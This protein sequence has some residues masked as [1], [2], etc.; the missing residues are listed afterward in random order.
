VATS[1]KKSRKLEM[2]PQRERWHRAAAAVIAATRQDRD[3]T[4]ADFAAQTRWSHDA[5]ANI[6]SGRRKI[7]FG[8]VVMAAIAIEEKPEILYNVPCGGTPQQIEPVRQSAIL[9]F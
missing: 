9:N 8:D 3:V 7:E 2:Q 5:V 4:P 1:K 6:E